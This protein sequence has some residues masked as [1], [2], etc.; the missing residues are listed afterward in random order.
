MIRQCND[1]LV[2]LDHQHRIVLIPQ[3]EK[4]VTDP[5]HI[6][7][8]QSRGRFIED[9]GDIAQAAAQMPDH[10]QPLKLAA[11]QCVRAAGE[12][13]IAQADPN[14]CLQ[15][16]TDLLRQRSTQRILYRFQYRN[17]TGHLHIVIIHDIISVD[18]RSQRR[19]IQAATAAGGTGMAAHKGQR[20]FLHTLFQA[21][22]VSIPIQAIKPRDNAFVGQVRDLPCIFIDVVDDQRLLCA[23]PQYLPLLR[24]IIPQLLVGIKIGVIGEVN[25]LPA[26]AG[27]L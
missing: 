3:L 6:R 21:R 7:W 27:K 5:L 20:L 4:K 1:L 23:D 22:D 15:T 10:L 11:G 9:I 13:Q 25:A 16:D 24:R 8:M 26:A 14:H 18:A 17:Q 2:M 12:R 19:R